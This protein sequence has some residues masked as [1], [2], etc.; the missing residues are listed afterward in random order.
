M[1]TSRDKTK[2]LEDHPSGVVADLSARGL[3][4]AQRVEQRAETTLDLVLED[5]LSLSFNLPAEIQRRCGPGRYVTNSDY[6]ECRRESS[7]G[8]R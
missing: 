2:E 3:P 7:C 8:W 4:S 6:S 5:A 1:P